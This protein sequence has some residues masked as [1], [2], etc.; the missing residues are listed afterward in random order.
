MTASGYNE[1]SV[2]VPSPVED[3]GGLSAIH[4]QLRGLREHCREIGG[5][6]PRPSTLR[7]ALGNIFVSLLR[8]LTFW[9]TPPIQQTI[10][11]LIDALEE[12]TRSLEQESRRL[13]GN[14][15][16]MRN[17]TSDLGAR[18]E[19]EC[20]HRA[21]VEARLQGDEDELRH[22][23]DRISGLQA[24]LEEQIHALELERAT[25]ID[26]ENNAREQAD[27][28]QQFQEERSSQEEAFAAKLR[29]AEER[30]QLLRRE[31]LDQ[32]R[33]VS[34][35]L[36]EARKRLPEA[37]NET[38][39]R[40]F[41]QE[42]MR[43]LDPLYACVEDELRGTRGEMQERWKA[44][45]PFLNRES[46]VLDVGCGGGEWL[47][48]LRREGFSARGVDRNPLLVEE[49][50]ERGLAIEQADALD[51]LRGLP[52][53]SLGAV[54]VFHLLEHLP[55]PNWIRLLDA[56]ARA[57][58]PDGVA[59][60]ET[61]N[62]DNVL[63]GSRDFYLDPSHRRPIPSGTLRFL[64]EARGFTRIQVLPLN[65]SDSC[66]L[67]PGEESSE[68]AQKFNRYFYGPRDYAVVAWKPSISSQP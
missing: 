46:P 32:S 9:Y 28:F 44:Y 7:A 21:A 11:G 24:R 29:L 53:S 8:R 42:S 52:D 5:L 60:F 13:Q 54:T 17:R 56:A 65:P 67:V 48:L 2:F 38:Q 63:V 58:Q 47:E 31:I 14:E 26:L 1:H 51:Y 36:E 64:L 55:F 57:L 10:G 33:R 12:I 41:E 16:E 22:E 50:R 15:N 62:P 49:C 39:L 43:D 37:L 19:Q 59:I 35:L 25:T 23:R 3:S 18:L 4:D 66:N 34:L 45:L 40:T 68:L 61:P 6:P 30:L 20:R 27:N